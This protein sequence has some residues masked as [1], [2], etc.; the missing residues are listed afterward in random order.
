MRLPRAS[1]VFWWL[2]YKF[3]IVST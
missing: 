1:T 2:V 3:C